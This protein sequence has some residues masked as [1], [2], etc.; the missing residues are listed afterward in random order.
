[1]TAEFCIQRIKHTHAAS[2]E[3]NAILWIKAVRKDTKCFLYYHIFEYITNYRLNSGQWM[4]NIST[5]SSKN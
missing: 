5:E 4:K 1:M 3:F 2:K